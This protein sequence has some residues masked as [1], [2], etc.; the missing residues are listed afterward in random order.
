M[1]PLPFNALRAVSCR[2]TDPDSGCVQKRKNKDK[3]MGWTRGCLSCPSTT[4]LSFLSW[5]KRN[6][7]GCANTGRSILIVLLLSFTPKLFQSSTGGKFQGIYSPEISIFMNGQCYRRGMRQGWV[8]TPAA[9]GREEQREILPWLR[10]KT[11]K[12]TTFPHSVLAKLPAHSFGCNVFGTAM[13]EMSSV[14]ENL[15]KHEDV[16]LW[17]TQKQ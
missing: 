7:V 2:S 11:G 13:C 8:S 12:S 15:S 10:R 16:F 3:N 14:S 1:T 5:R 6:P 17:I 9:M 4:G